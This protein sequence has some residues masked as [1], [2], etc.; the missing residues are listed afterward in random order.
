MWHALDPAPPTPRLPRVPPRH[1][2]QL[3]VVDLFAGAG[4]ISEGFRQA[5]FA[6]I[7]GLDND[8][9][10]A[11]TYR[12]NFPEAM[13]ATGD[14]RAPD[15]KDRVLAA[16]RSAS[17][18][19]GGPP[20][21]AFSQMRNHTR[22][23][24]DPRNALY[25]EFVH[26]LRETAPMA[27]V[28][29]NVTG[30]DQMGVRAQIAADLG[31]DGEYA[32]LP[33]VVDAADF[34]VPQTRKRL[35]F[36]GVRRSLGMTPPKMRGTGATEAVS[37]VRVMGPGRPRYEVVVQESLLSM[38]IADA[39][40]NPDDLMVVTVADALSDLSGLPVGNRADALPY[41]Q[42]AEPTS[43]YQ[44][45][46]RLG[47]GHTLTNVQVPR[48][49][50]DTRLRLEGIPNGGNHRDLSGE[51]LDRYITGQ[52]WGQD[53]GTGRL[54]RRHFYA[55]R[56]LHPS[57]WAWTLN[58]K[59]DSVYHYEHPRALSVREF[60]R[61][62]S[63]PDRFTFTTDPRQGMIEGRHDGGPAHS[64]YRQVGNAVPPLLA[65]AVATALLAEVTAAR[66]REATLAKSA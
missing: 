63:F 26:V 21:Q 40:A 28:M 51:L 24:D 33:Q 6:V 10:A 22:V 20:C 19:V 39:L 12:R 38:R 65:R 61:L 15:V 25:R 53:N 49:N 4:G 57:V 8:P 1:E 59:G 37:L 29:E 43:A 66:E 64:R 9:D 30:M 35:L 31:L 13:V 56:R 42:V 50:A 3:T 54:S 32:V 52:R 45:E 34:G 7:A 36:V 48:I 2:T 60:A 16:A 55:Y 58:T 11:A 18:L 47:A 62:Q 41:A 23:I 27:F 5:G 44:R 14:L 17:V 46:M